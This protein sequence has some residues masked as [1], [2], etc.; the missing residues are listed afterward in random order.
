MRVGRD[1]AADAAVPPPFGG[2]DGRFE[3]MLAASHER[4]SAMYGTRSLSVVGRQGS[5]SDLHDSQ[6]R[7]VTNHRY[8]IR[9]SAK[10]YAMLISLW[11]YG[12]YLFTMFFLL[13]LCPGFI[14][15]VFLVSSII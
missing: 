13:M 5:L 2:V 11:C 4:H 7:L 9:C 3:A 6:M 8:S 12:V 15:E 14:N 10:T 1:G